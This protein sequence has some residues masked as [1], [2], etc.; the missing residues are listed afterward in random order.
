MT[1]QEAPQQPARK[2][3]ADI[4]ATD[5]TKTEEVWVPEWDT[6]VKVVGLTKRQQLDIR[7][8]SLVDGAIDEDKSQ[9][10]MWREGVLEPK[11]DE[12]QMVAVF[13]KSAGAVD[14]ILKTVLNL[15][16]MGD[17]STRIIEAEFRPG[18]R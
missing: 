16:G 5:D 2:S 13:E 6:F 9:A 8:A 10:E 15:S 4:L 14:R 11:F 17:G 3:A 18:Q 7:K 12:S 1:D